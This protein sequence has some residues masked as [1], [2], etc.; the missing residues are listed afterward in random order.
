[1]LDDERL[2]MHIRLSALSLSNLDIRMPP[3]RSCPLDAY[4]ISKRAQNVLLKF[5]SMSHPLYKREP[6]RYITHHQ[7]VCYS[8]GY[9]LDRC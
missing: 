6:R 8:P 9:V 5:S 2:Y 4:A 1:V 7:P 3:D